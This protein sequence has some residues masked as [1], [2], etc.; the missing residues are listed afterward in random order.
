MTFLVLLVTALVLA[1]FLSHDPKGET[2]D[3][4]PKIH[5]MSEAHNPKD[6]TSNPC[7]TWDLRPETR[8]PE[9]GFTEESVSF[10]C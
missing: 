4:R 6:E 10:E 2:R 7:Y 8:D 9:S 5:L 1:F 3:P